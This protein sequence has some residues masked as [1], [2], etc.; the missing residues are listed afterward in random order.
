MTRASFVVFSLA[1]SLIGCRFQTRGNGVKSDG[2]R[3]SAVLTPDSA[4]FTFRM[5]A[6]LVWVWNA[7]DTSW[8]GSPQYRWA[9][10]SEEPADVFFG[11]GLE[12]ML[13][14]PARENHKT[15]GLVE[16]VRDAHAHALGIPP[17][18]LDVAHVI[19]P[20]PAI[21]ATV[22]KGQVVFTLRQSPTL[23]RLLA[24]HPHTM[25]LMFRVGSEEEELADTVVVVYR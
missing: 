19:V 2:P 23:R 16:L 9:A 13:L 3:G 10:I 17:G 20:E 15:G 14:K 5:P 22:K 1:I 12:L 6:Q 4:V 8:V 7:P 21:S 24:A 25:E 11:E 18:D